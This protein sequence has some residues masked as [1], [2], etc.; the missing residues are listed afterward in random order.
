MSNG[1]H[2]VSGAGPGLKRT[3]LGPLQYR[4]P[5]SIEWVTAAAGLPG[6]HIAPASRKLVQYRCCWAPGWT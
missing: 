6:P 5:E 2:P 1:T 4:S 3:L